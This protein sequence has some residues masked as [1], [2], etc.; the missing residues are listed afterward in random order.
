MLSEVAIRA[1]PRRAVLRWVTRLLCALVAIGAGA[2]VDAVAG[3]RDDGVIGAPLCAQT[4]A[5]IARAAAIATPFMRCFM[6]LSSVAVPGRYAAKGSLNPRMTRVGFGPGDND[7]G[8]FVPANTQPTGSHIRPHP[9]RINMICGDGLF[10]RLLS[11]VLLMNV[12]G[13]KSCRA[14]GRGMMPAAVLLVCAIIAPHPQMQTHAPNGARNPQNP[15]DAARCSRVPAKVVRS[16]TYP[17]EMPAIRPPAWISRCAGV[18]K[19]SRPIVMCHEM[20]Q[21]TPTITHAAANTTASACHVSAVLF[22]DS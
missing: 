21:Y 15:T 13:E 20:S 6:P 22:E 4:G 17:D 1:L 14:L 11:S 12:T 9:R 8:C 18:Q 3:A 2:A 5:A 16:A 7:A 19:E 10:K